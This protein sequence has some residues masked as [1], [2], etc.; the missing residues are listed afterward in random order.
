[1][2]VWEWGFRL[3]VTWLY[4][5]LADTIEANT[6]K[7]RRDATKYNYKPHPYL[8]YARTDTYYEQDGIRIWKTFYRRE[9]NPET[10]RVACLGGS[11][12]QNQFS[13]LLQEELTRVSG[14]REIEVMDFGCNGWTLME[15]TINYLIRVVEFK[16]DV[17]LVHHGVNDSF[18]RRWTGFKPDYT[19]YRSWWN[20]RSNPI[21]TKLAGISWFVSYLQMKRGVSRTALRNFTVYK[22]PLEEDLVEQTPETLVSFRRNLLTLIHLTRA[23]GSTLVLAPM[24]YNRRV[25]SVSIQR[26]G[27]LIE[28]QNDCMRGL[29]AAENVSLADTDV[30]LE[31][32]TERFFDL[33]H[34]DERGNRLKAFV[35]ARA[36]WKA[37]QGGDAGTPATVIPEGMEIEHLWT[38]RVLEIR[39]NLG[40]SETIADYHVYMRDDPAEDF[41]FLGQTRSGDA[42]S[43]LWKQDGERTAK[44]FSFGP[45]HDKKY[46]FA[47]YA[48]PQSGKPPALGPFFGPGKVAVVEKR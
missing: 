17:V 48:L 1:L 44:K 9:K 10:I 27:S 30:L 18:P 41:V 3:G 6:R 2:L 32:H 22:S 4:P 31:N 34:V 8:S 47:V 45:A 11:T 25:K 23:S 42:H 46:E 20:D 15:S 14:G 38:N 24:P 39:W 19:H 36:V 43:F 40:L 26:Y 13:T 33:V 5:E 28:E 21:E 16:P 29:A 12:T 35:F 7:T 37:L